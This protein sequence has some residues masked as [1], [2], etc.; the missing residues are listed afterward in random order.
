MTSPAIE[1]RPRRPRGLLRLAFRLP[2]LLYRCHLGWLLGH[3]FLL[4]TH[5]G[6]R[7]G[8]VHD[9]MLEV[10]LYDPT[11]QESIVL[12]GMGTRADW[13]RN[14]A[15]NP[16]LAIRTGRLHYLPEHRVLTRGEAAA[17][18]ARWEHAHPWE[19]R[20]ALPVLKRLGWAAGG[21]AAHGLPP[22]AVLVAFRPSARA[23]DHPDSPVAD[24]D[25]SHQR[26]R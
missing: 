8:A 2:V 10:L 18:A 25:G 9:T 6:R 16:A 3:R 23:S 22:D 24:K 12:S 21:V 1:H 7:T 5:R 26:R 11:T 17:A 15:A 4:L 19:A 13:Y 20:L 14:I